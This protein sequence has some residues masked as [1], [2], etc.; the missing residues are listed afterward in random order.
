MRVCEGVLGDHS[1]RVL[2]VSA[3]LVTAFALDCLLRDICIADSLERE[4]VAPSGAESSI[5]SWPM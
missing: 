3:S 4:I 5:V 1:S 2:H